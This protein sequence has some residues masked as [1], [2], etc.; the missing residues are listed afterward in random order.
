MHVLRPAR[1]GLAR[2][3]LVIGAALALLGVLATWL[4]GAVSPPRAVVAGEHPFFR[5][6]LQRVLQAEAWDPEDEGA[7]WTAA[8]AG[9]GPRLFNAPKW[10]ADALPCLSSRPW[11][12]QYLSSREQDHHAGSAVIDVLASSA[13]EFVLARGRESEFAASRGVRR[14]NLTMAAFWDATPAGAPLPYLYHHGPLDR[15]PPSLQADAAR[16]APTLAVLDAP[17][18]TAADAWPAPSTNVWMAHQGVAA[19][20]HYDPS[21]NV[22]LQV[23]GAKVWLLWPPEQ[24]PALR[25]HPHSHPSRRQTRM[26]L[27]PLATQAPPLAAGAG[28]HP[29]YSRTRALRVT[30]APGQ[31]L[32]VPP[33]WAHA[34][35]TQEA[36][37]SLSVV[38]PSWYEATWAAARWVPLPYASVPAS[39]PRL[40]AQ[41]LGAF[42]R[43]LLPRVAAIRGQTGRA[44]LAGVHE[45]RHAPVL[46]AGELGG[47]A[48][49]GAGNDVTG[50]DALAEEGEHG[51]AVAR[52]VSR[53]CRAASATAPPA[54]A[55]PQCG[56][57]EEADEEVVTAA[58]GGTAQLERAAAAVA[59]VLDATEPDDEPPEQAAAPAGGAP[60]R[61]R[62]RASSKS[63]GSDS[64]VSRRRR[65]PDAVAR[66]LLASYVE[67]Q[68]A[69][70]AGTEEEEAL[71]STLCCFALW[72]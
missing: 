25:L 16:L 17:A 58:A 35:L 20:T 53:A 70:A 8:L 50:N 54:L 41:A 18:G 6:P 13:A 30:V 65:F 72:L 45:A 68:I 63:A 22:V 44:F 1:P 24:L 37:V 27:L 7:A 36:G 15:W 2:G 48:G 40:R 3:A 56:W 11:S 69:W 34:V 42:L 60:K 26:Q 57:L 43:H 51:E 14:G 64:R 31:L 47:V 59:A 61:R 4:P 5:V 19:T 9:G 10:M 23:A 12:P 66:E 67:D 49:G 39:N 71:A 46:A 21:H 29:G 62:K 55:A 38:S 32:Y 52:G 28:A 33:Y